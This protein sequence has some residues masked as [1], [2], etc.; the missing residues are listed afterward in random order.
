MIFITS[1]G[2]QECCQCGKQKQGASVLL[3]MYGATESFYCYEHLQ[4][5]LN[6]LSGTPVGQALMELGR[7]LIPELLKK[8]CHQQ[9]VAP[10][11]RIA[12][13]VADAGEAAAQPTHNVRGR[14]TDN[15][16]DC[17][18]TPEQP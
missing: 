15:G 4:R 16:H 18:L 5:F 11:A 10:A 7:K 12:R 2:K 9:P 14:T 3:Y 17:A 1:V 8:A 13:E 6:G